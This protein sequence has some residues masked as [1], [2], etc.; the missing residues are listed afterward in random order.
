MSG[1]TRTFLAVELPG[2][3]KALLRQLEDRLAPDAR[4]VRWVAPE[5]CHLTLAFLGDV[6]DSKLERVCQ[7]A[8]AA[9]AT[10]S[11]FELVLEGLGAFP[12]PARPRVVWAG[13]TGPG[14]DAL[15]TLQKAAAAALRTAGLPP[16][17]DRFSPHVTIGRIKPGRGPAPN[18][19]T[20]LQR[21]Q[22]WSA[23]PFPVS[24]VVT[25]ASVLAPSGPS[26]TTLS[27]TPLGAGKPPTAP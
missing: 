4:G 5:L 14:L 11:P 20:L 24:E 15:R 23:G 18:L 19:T 12:N 16:A 1:S 7:A 8:G 9:A 27:R 10:V 2:S 13:L 3:H 21:Y 22:D 26:Y 17:D 25:Y 6:P